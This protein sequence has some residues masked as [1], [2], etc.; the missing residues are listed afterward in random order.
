MKLD[1][2]S[3]R[4]AVE[5]LEK[6][7]NVANDEI[8]M[9]RLN[10]DQKKTVRAGVIQNF[11]FTYELC[12]KFMRRWLEVNLG[13][14]Y[15]AGVSRRQLFR[16]SAE[17]RLIDDVDRWMVFHDARNETSHTYDENTAEDVFETAQ[18]FLDDAQVLL[19]ALEARND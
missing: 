6:A 9:S 5:S 4:K 3:L 16:L 19:E 17:H 1:L 10:D 2:S 14:A 18:T 7:L 8:F 11:E 12:W 13:M 15:V